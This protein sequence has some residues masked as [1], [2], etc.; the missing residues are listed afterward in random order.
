MERMV[1]P[2]QLAARLERERL[3]GPDGGTLMVTRAGERL[4]LG[5]LPEARRQG[6]GTEVQ[7]QLAE[8]L[9]AHTHRA[10][11][12]RESL[13]SAA[14]GGSGGLRSRKTRLFAI[15]RRSSPAGVPASRSRP[16]GQ[17][18]QDDLPAGWFCAELVRRGLQVIRFADR[19]AGLVHRAEAAHGPGG[20]V[21]GTANL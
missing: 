12:S 14:P 10:P 16:S 18:R 19:I 4:G 5:M 17:Q 9:F 13:S 2:A 1:R 3:M 8:Y 15:T 11:L 7:R 21:P 6:D 20:P